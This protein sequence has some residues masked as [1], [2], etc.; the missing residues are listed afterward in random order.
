MRVGHGFDI[1]RLVSGRKLMLG[2]V[3]IPFAQGL[4]G[5]SDGD[6]LIHAIIDALLGA[7]G[8]GDIGKHFPSSNENYRGA[9]G[10]ALLSV[11]CSLLNKHRHKIVNIDATIIC[12]QPRLSESYVLMQEAIAQALNITTDLINIK[13][14]TMDR[15]GAIGRGEAIAAEAVALID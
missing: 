5:H 14:K 3:H 1:H 9:S 15:L 11:I 7:A 10:I 13:S 6:V 4:L 12:E 2:G 8:L